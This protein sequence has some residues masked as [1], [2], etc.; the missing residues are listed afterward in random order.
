MIDSANHSI[1]FRVTK[2]MTSKIK[3]KQANKQKMSIKNKAFVKKG[4]SSTFQ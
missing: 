4:H 2:S 1:H 3:S